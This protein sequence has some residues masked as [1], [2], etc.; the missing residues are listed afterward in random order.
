LC[1]VVI[2]FA[3]DSWAQFASS[4]NFG[5]SLGGASGISATTTPSM[6][7]QVSL[8]ALWQNGIAHH[9]S[10]QMGA[11]FAQIASINQGGYSQYTAN[12]IPIDVRLRYAPL[13]SEKWQPFI[14]AG[15]G[16]I[17]YSINSTPALSQSGTALFFPAGIGLRHQ[18]DK[19][20]AIEGSVGVHPTMTDFLNPIPDKG[21]D[22]YW[23][24]SIGLTVTLGSPKTGELTED[25]F[26]LGDRGDVHIL[27]GVVF[28]SGK[29]SLKPESDTILT[30][31]LNTLD[32]HADILV[33]FRDY[34]DNSADFY[35]SMALTQQR[36]ESVKVWFVSRGIAA[37]RIST[38][39]YGPHNPIVQNTSPENMAINRRLE[40]VRMK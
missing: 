18:L 24:F 5:G 3:E 7:A 16:I 31:I 10:L 29:A 2:L 20:F 28:D 33:E 32:A 26:D 30:K 9:L 4:W 13:D 8:Y 6:S 25:E 36:A 11:G 19:E 38:V 34:L 12:I 40:I 1:I 39:G 35:T 37:S 23:G 22:A 21:K 14:Y 17:P 27:Y 15:V